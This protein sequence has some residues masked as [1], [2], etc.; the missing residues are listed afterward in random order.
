MCSWCWGIAQAIHRIADRDDVELRVIVGGLRPG[1][2]AQPLDDQLRQQLARLWDKVASVSG[3]PFDKAAL[4][5][6]AWVYDTELTANAVTTMRRLSPFDT[7]TRFT[8]LQTSFYADTVDITDQYTG[9]IA[10]Y[11]VDPG[12]F[13][14]ELESDEAKTFAW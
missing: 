13:M 4:E 7:L 1:P 11:D 2:N 12:R 8:H 14:A 5:R 9:L 3:Q 10:G 6:P